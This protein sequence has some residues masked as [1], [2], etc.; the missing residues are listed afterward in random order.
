MGVS[1]SIDD[2]TSSGQLASR[3]ESSSEPAL[4][5]VSLSV[6]F[7]EHSSFS[8]RPVVSRDGRQFL[9]VRFPPRKRK[10]RVLL[11]ATGWER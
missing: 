8:N 5:S 9:A 4:L 2:G 1:S 6:D 7:F 3:Q 11:N 10:E